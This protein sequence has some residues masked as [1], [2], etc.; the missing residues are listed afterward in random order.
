MTSRELLFQLNID[1]QIREAL[2]SRPIPQHNAYWRTRVEYILP[3]P[4]YYFIPLFFDLLVKQGISPNALVSEPHLQVMESILDSVARFECNQITFDLHRGNCRFFIEKHGIPQNKIREVDDH[5]VNRFFSKIPSGFTALSR[6]NTFLYA[7]AHL[8]D[9]YPLIAKTWES[10][11][12]LILFLDDIEDFRDDLETHQENCLLEGPS[13]EESFFQLHP[14]LQELTRSLQPINPAI[15]HHL[16][17]LR[18]Q[19]VSKGL[20]EITLSM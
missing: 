13:P 7:F 12:P 10:T 2:L 17:N 19:A 11:M 3:S 9:D 6:A 16:D 4:G 8:S 20:I 14:I 5:L 15:Y 18:K 1:P